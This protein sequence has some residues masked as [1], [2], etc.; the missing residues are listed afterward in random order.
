MLNI[1]APTVKSYRLAPKQDV[2]GNFCNTISNKKDMFFKIK[3]KF[4]LIETVE[5]CLSVRDW[6]VGGMGKVGQRVQTFCKMKV[7]GHGVLGTND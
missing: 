4:E 1:S 3:S 5:W 2:K 6:E 7:L